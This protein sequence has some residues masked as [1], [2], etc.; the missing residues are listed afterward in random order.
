V[1][2]DPFFQNER[3]S[4][5]AANLGNQSFKELTRKWVSESVRAKY[6]YG[7]DW[8][9]VPII[10]FPTDLIA[11]Q[12]IVWKVRPNTVIECGI[13]RGGSAIFWASMQ[14]ICGIKPNVISIDIDI[15]EHTRNAIGS[16]IFH[17]RITL[18]EGHSTSSEVVSKVDELVAVNDIVLVILDSNHTHEHVLKELNAYS[19]FVSK[20][21]YLLVLDTL[22]EKLEG[23]PLKE[24][25]PG[26]SPL[27]AVN[28]FMKSNQDF[29][30]EN[31]YENLIGIT[32][33]PNGYLKKIR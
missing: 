25:G 6:T 26:D 9:G 23:D 28:V 5:Q 32:V 16:S 18:L 33:A 10:Q 27:T 29:I 14:L 15:R 4:I 12:D 2:F 7:F 22:I 24:W 31:Y 3:E 21:S 17:E 30:V 1:I 13:A 20:D 11:F 19:K 8:L